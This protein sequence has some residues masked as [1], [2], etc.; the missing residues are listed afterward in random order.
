MIR[1]R[2]RDHRLAAVSAIL[3]RVDW[4]VVFFIVAIAIAG[5]LQSGW[6]VRGILVVPL[7]WLGLIPVELA[8]HFAIHTHF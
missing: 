4:M 3:N 8:V 2:R 6:M 5:C 1:T 7:V